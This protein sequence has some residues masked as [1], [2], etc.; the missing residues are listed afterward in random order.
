[1]T[2]GSCRR[3]LTLEAGESGHI[4]HYLREDSEHPGL[5]VIDTAELLVKQQV[6]FFVC[7]YV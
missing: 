4:V 7:H 5:G 2:G 1:M 3:K 6:L